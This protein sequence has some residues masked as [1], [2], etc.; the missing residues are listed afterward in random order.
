MRI[1]RKNEL[2]KWLNFNRHLLILVFVLSAKLT[3]ASDLSTLQNFNSFGKTPLKFLGFN[4]Y[5]IEL[6]GEKPSFSYNQKLAI[7]I[8]YNKSF[9][10]EDLV[11]TSISEIC[12]IN[13]IRPAEIE[14]DYRKKFDT[15]FV[16]VKKGDEKVAIYDPKSGLELYFNGKLTGKVNDTNFAKR[17]IDIWL[18][19]NARF[20]EVRDVLVRGK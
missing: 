19:E 8:K 10:K 3:Y 14:E 11:K 6:R 18:S 7:I 17:F 20:R 2:K 1:E 5:D 16:D 9:S 13:K 4:L 15:L 12:R